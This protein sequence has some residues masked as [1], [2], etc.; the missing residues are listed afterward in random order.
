MYINIGEEK[1]SEFK[2]RAIGSVQTE[3]WRE[4]A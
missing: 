1:I 3:A 2:D 4:K